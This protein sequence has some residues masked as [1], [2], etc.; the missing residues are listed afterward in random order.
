VM[1]GSCTVKVLPAEAPTRLVTC[2]DPVVALTGT[3]Q[4][5]AVSDQD[6]MVAGFPLN[7]TDP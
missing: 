5:I 7:F 4:V 3:A 6:V 2:T 1:E